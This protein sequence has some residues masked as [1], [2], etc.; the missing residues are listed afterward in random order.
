MRILIA[1]S[2][3]KRLREVFQ[4]VHQFVQNA[5]PLQLTVQAEVLPA[6]VLEE[7]NGQVVLHRK[8][9]ENSFWN[10]FLNTKGN[11]KF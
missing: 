2:V 1:Y 8:D 7:Q 11:I 6:V 4:I 5:Q 9:V 3:R 10:Y